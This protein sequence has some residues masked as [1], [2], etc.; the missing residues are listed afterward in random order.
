MII[1]S[2]GFTN[3]ASTDL[4]DKLNLYTTK[5]SIPYKL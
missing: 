5:H 2:G 4:V 3:V 1:D